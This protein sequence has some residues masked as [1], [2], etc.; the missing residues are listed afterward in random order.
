MQGISGS[1]LVPEAAV[2]IEI[3]LSLVFQEIL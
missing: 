1:I 3:L 2:T